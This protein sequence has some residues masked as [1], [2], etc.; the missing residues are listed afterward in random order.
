MTREIQAP[1]LVDPAEGEGT[2]T[3]EDAGDGAGD[4]GSDEDTDE[5]EGEI[6]PELLVAPGE[7]KD[8]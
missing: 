7:E 3:I 6:Q 5:E 8:Q 4:G 1:E 2:E